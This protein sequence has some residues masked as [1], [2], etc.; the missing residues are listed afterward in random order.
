MSC[1]YPAIEDNGCAGEAAPTINDHFKWIDYKIA[2]IVA[3]T[4]KIATSI[5]SLQSIIPTVAYLQSAVDGVSGVSHIEA[6]QNSLTTF[7]NLTCCYGKPLTL[8]YPYEVYS[9]AD[10]DTKIARWINANFDP[11]DEACTFNE[12]YIIA[13]KGYEDEKAINRVKMPIQNYEPVFNV[14]KDNER[15]I[16]GR[17]YRSGYPILAWQASPTLSPFACANALKTKIDICK[18]IEPTTV[19]YYKFSSCTIPGLV[20]YSS[21]DFSYLIGLGAI[22][23]GYPNDIFLVSRVTASNQV[24]TNTLSVLL[25]TKSGCGDSCYLLTNEFGES[26]VSTS[27]ILDAYACRTSV[28]LEGFTGT[29][30]VEKTTEGCDCACV[31]TVSR[32]NVDVYRLTNCCAAFL[33]CPD[34]QIE[35]LP[36]EIWVYDNTGKNYLQAGKAVELKEYPG[37]RWSIT[38]ER[39]DNQKITTD[40]KVVDLFENCKAFIKPNPKPKTYFKLVGSCLNKFRTDLFSES[41]ILLPYVGKVVNI[42]FDTN[43]FYLVTEFVTDSAVP[44]TV[45][46]VDVNLYGN[47][48]PE[49]TT[50]TRVI[51]SLITNQTAFEDV[52]M[53]GAEYY[54][55]PAPSYTDKPFPVCTRR[56]T[57]WNDTAMGS[58][59][60]NNIE[61][62]SKILDAWYDSDSWYSFSTNQLSELVKRSLGL[63]DA[64]LTAYL[65][66]NN[67]FIEIDVTFKRYRKIFRP[68]LNQLYGE[69]TDSIGQID[70]VKIY[71]AIISTV[72]SESGLVSCGSVYRIVD[73]CTGESRCVV[74][75]GN[76]LRDAGDTAMIDGSPSSI[77][78]TDSSDCGSVTYVRDGQVGANMSA[79]EAQLYCNSFSR[80]T[81][82]DPAQ[83]LD[84]ECNPIILYYSTTNRRWHYNA[85]LTSGSLVNG[86]YTGGEGVEGMDTTLLY[87]FLN[88][89]Y[90]EIGPH[91]CKRK[92]VYNQECCGQGE[93][94]VWIDP[95]I[96]GKVHDSVVGCNRAQ[97]TGGCYSVNGFYIKPE[98]PC[99]RFEVTD[100]I[101]TSSDPFYCHTVEYYVDCN[102]NMVTLY[103]DTIHGYYWLSANDAC[104]CQGLRFDS[105]GPYGLGSAP[106]GGSGYGFVDGVRIANPNLCGAACGCHD[107]DSGVL[108]LFDCPEY[109]LLD[110]APWIVPQQSAVT[111]LPCTNAGQIITCG[112]ACAVPV[113]SACGCADIDSG[114]LDLFDCALTG[115]ANPQDFVVPATAG[116]GGREC[117]NAGST[118][119]CGTAC[120][121]PPYNCCT[122]YGYQE[123]PLEGWGSNYESVSVYCESPIDGY[124][125]CYR[126]VA[127]TPTPTPVPPTPTATPVPP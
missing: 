69:V 118:I 48:F 113:P 121:P 76:K 5:N 105:E 97:E 37:V 77:S 124:V 61:N 99:V 10:Y 22:L 56:F 82:G 20:F 110:P 36:K 47:I 19:F 40:Y 9:K 14:E 68:S 25:V 86:L 91:C 55:S 15:F 35:N 4:E 58:W 12:L 74:T 11:T 94:M 72:A 70:R 50:A 85:E 45:N 1:I 84:E 104:S 2:D 31:V 120:N 17:F 87:R 89:K 21:Q 108:D 81:F 75:G 71:S 100:C 111:L 30:T 51:N 16:V 29:W 60:K 119:T 103:K 115:L 107:I 63:S 49:F 65:S 90:T 8:F 102:D 112:T 83:F 116:I 53:E 54:P 43:N 27:K 42:N 38:I 3:S 67:L 57:Y 93:T 66:S 24:L 78:I 23:D 6:F 79:E 125:D 59:V 122:D 80:P 32:A 117:S 96:V 46:I 34:V 62:H 95:V 101:E 13:F 73:V 127:P 39:F 88:G 44:T 18:E 109:G 52:V 7:P 92:V 64:A 26:I 41:S 33:P 106:T 114:L 98:E 126:Y 123:T 28:E